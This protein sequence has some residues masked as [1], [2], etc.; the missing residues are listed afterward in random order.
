MEITNPY[1]YLEWLF[2][3]IDQSTYTGLVRG[4][5]KTLLYLLRHPG[6]GFSLASFSP[7]G[8]RVWAAKVPASLASLRGRSG[9]RQGEGEMDTYAKPF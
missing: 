2:L 3:P 7:R 8:E 4:L 5:S 9:Q 6:A 1:T